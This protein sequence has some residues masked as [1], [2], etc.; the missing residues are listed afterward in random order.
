MSSLQRKNWSASRGLKRSEAE[1]EKR[2]LENRARLGLWR[3][4]RERSWRR[5][6]GKRS[7]SRWG[8]SNSWILLGQQIQD[9][10]V[11]NDTFKTFLFGEEVLYFV[12]VG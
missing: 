11:P 7:I 5:C 8:F 9:I 2:V 10:I 6:G 4:R 12:L 3:R 1:A